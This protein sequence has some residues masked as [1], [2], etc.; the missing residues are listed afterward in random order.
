[1]WMRVSRM[2]L[3]APAAMTSRPPPSASGFSYCE[4]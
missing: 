1:M 3:A 4:I 2:R